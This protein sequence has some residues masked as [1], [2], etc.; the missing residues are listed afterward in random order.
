M[1][2]LL[3][4]TTDLNP[5][6]QHIKPWEFVEVATLVPSLNKPNNA[7]YVL[8]KISEPVALNSVIISENLV[9]MPLLTLYYIYSAGLLFGYLIEIPSFIVKVMS[10][11]VTVLRP[12]SRKEPDFKDATLAMQNAHISVFHSED[13]ASLVAFNARFEKLNADILKGGSGI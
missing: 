13:G 3:Q 7:K 11:C 4:L 12:G 6:F 10:N 2:S 1:P 9:K 8:V 5:L